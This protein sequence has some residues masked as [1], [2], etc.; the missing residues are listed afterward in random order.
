MNNLE[1]GYKT[2]KE[3][4]VEDKDSAKNMGSGGLEVLATPILACWVEN[5]AFELLEL[6][7]DDE[8]TSVGGKIDL[9]HI[10][11]T[12]IGLKISIELT[13]EEID[14]S[15][16]VFSFKAFDA[17]Q[18]VGNGIHERF[19]VN[20]EKFVVKVLKKKNESR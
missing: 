9:N 7:L 2:K 5:T 11:P 3:F 18:E 13:L 16:Y 10:S 1:V 17:V 20:K 15:R 4:V 8:S 14:R 19:V 6:N 12:P